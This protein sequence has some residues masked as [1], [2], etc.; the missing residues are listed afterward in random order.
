MKINVASP[1][2][3]TQKI[4]EV[5]EEKK[6][7]TLMDK[8]VSDE[9][10]GDIL[11][12]KFKGYTLK[13]TGGQDKQGFPMKQGVLTNTRVRLLLNRGDVGF[14]HWRGREGERRRKSVRGCIVANDVA[15]L[16]CIV[17][18]EGPDKVE[19]LNDHIIPRRLGPKRASK[20]RRL[21]NL[22]KEDDVRKFVIR[23]YLP[24]KEGKDGK[25]RRARTKAPKIQ[26]LITPVVLERRK[27]KR[28]LLKDRRAKAREEYEE[29][30]TLIHRRVVLSAHRK[31]AAKLN[32]LH[33]Q[34]KKE[35]LKQR[36]KQKKEAIR[37]AEKKPASPAKKSSKKK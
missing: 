19:G 17:I 21:F 12:D 6:L 32:A 2:T 34:K 25:K 24:E 4:F 31:R 8:R 3:G 1:L 9:F 11:G 7:V 16:N 26:R 33:A 18:K 27:R 15:V 28:R 35:L 22:T 10:A 36:R 23:R 20:L 5:D 13:I 37:A 30:Q 14:Q 29:Y